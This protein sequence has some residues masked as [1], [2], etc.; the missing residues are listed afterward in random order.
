[1]PRY[2]LIKVDYTQ[3]KE[4]NNAQKEGGSYKEFA[5]PFDGCFEMG[6]YEDKGSFRFDCNADDSMTVHYYGDSGDHCSGVDDYGDNWHA[7]F[8][9][10]SNILWV[11]SVQLFHD[12]SIIWI[13]CALLRD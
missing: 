10:L 4:C 5:L 3:D 1:M 9:S 7:E 11:K 6:E 2:V 12:L 8:P 13:C